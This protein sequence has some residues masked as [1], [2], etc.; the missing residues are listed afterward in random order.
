MKFKTKYDL[1]KNV[2]LG[3]SFFYSATLLL[4]VNAYIQWMKFGAYKEWVLE[5]PNYQ[6]I[7]E[8]NISRGEFQ[9]NLIQDTL[10][11]IPLALIFDIGIR[12]AYMTYQ[13]LK[14]DSN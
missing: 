3:L 12:Y 14:S 5:N 1:R 6:F 10:W 8:M 4:L 11:Y 2:L 13:E 9:S 7:P